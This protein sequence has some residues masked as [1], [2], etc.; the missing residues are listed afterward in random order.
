MRIITFF[1]LVLAVVA[2]VTAKNIVTPYK[3]GEKLTY[4]FYYGP[5][6][7][8]R[9]TFEVNTGKNSEYEKLTV[10]VKSNAFISALYPVEDELTSTFDPRYRR[11]IRFVQDRHEGGSHVWEESFF[12]YDLNHGEMLSYTTGESKWFEIPSSRV[13]DKVSTVYYMR[14]LD[15]M[16]RKKAE[17]LLG[18]DKS[19][20]KVT[21]TKLGLETIETDDFIPIPT[22]K[23][24]PNTEYLG[25][26]VKKGTMYVWVSND[27]FKVPVKVEANLPFGT[28]SA[29]LVN[30]EGIPGWKYSKE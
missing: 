9:G 1:F 29:I 7:V 25:G 3:P 6:M 27:Q 14:Y 20:Y 22:F 13:V 18:N 2:P 30:V 5:L 15:W 21:M 8:G 4:H 26:F 10:K 17:V 12:F 28:V 19:N 11:S 16:H 23:V 24:Q